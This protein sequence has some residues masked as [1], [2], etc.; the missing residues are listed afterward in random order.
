M[1]PNT[2]IYKT[3]FTLAFGQDVVVPAEIKNNTLRITKYNEEMNGKGLLTNLDFLEEEREK[4][5]SMQ[6]LKENRY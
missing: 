3:P 2:A 4:L 5:V 6:L 1:M